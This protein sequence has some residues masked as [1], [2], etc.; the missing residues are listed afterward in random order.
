[1]FTLHFFSPG[2][3]LPSGAFTSVHTQTGATERQKKTKETQ[4]SKIFHQSQDVYQHICL[5]R[6]SPLDSSNAQRK[7]LNKPNILAKGRSAKYSH[8]TVCLESFLTSHKQN[9]SWPK[10]HAFATSRLPPARSL[11]R[12]IKKVV[13]GR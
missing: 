10:R 3:H 11:R 1:M 5:Q 6:K 7:Q 13:Q 9:P 8:E 12:L 2:I 4:T